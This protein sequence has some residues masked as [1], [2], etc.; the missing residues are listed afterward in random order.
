[1]NYLDLV[2]NVLRRLRAEEVSG[3]YENQQSTIVADIVN[4]AK[5][6]VED[7]WDWSA[8]RTTITIPTVAGTSVYSLTGSQNRITIFDATNDTSKWWIDQR[9]QAW[10]RLFGLTDTPSSGGPCWYSVEPPDTAGDTTVKLYPEPDGIYMCTFAV[11]QRQADLAAEGDELTIPHMPV[12]YLAYALASTERGDAGG[13]GAQELFGT[14]KRML[15]DA[16]S[17]DTAYN[18]TDMIWYQV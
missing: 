17:Q 12:L 18:P 10:G 4:D 13:Q 6:Q 5:R 11:C 15:G 9:S 8:L 1:M 3:L 7:S 16:I 14:A 2:N